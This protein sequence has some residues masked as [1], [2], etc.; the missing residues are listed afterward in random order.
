MSGVNF[1]KKILVTG[2]TGS[3]GSFI[4][5]SSLSKK[6]FF[7]DKKKLNILNKNKIDSFFKKNK[8]DMI[9]HCAALAR[10]KD[11]ELNK[12]KAYQIN[13]KGTE[14][15]IKICK[16]YNPNIKFVY[17]SS[18]AVYPSINGNYNENS[19]LSAYNHYGKTKIMAEKKVKKIKNYLIIRTRFFNKQKIKYKDAAVDSFSSSIEINL[20]LKY[21]R[22]LINKK[23][24]GIFNVGGKKISDFDLYKKY[25]KNLKKTS[26]LKIQLN[27]K[28][29]LSIDASMNCKKFQKILNA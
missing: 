28:Y 4:K 20:L 22:V 15:L 23:I 18:D 14:N 29:S 7:P 11:C 2:S 25:K 9:I 3:L 8:L 27:K 19:K 10:M 16:K 24:S 17:I 6:C 12:K 13:V 26:I 5:K 1:K 21:L